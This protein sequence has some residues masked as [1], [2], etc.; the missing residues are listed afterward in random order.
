MK[1][2]AIYFTN[3]QKMHVPSGKLVLVGRD[4]DPE[5]LV[6]AVTGGQTTVYLD[7]ICAV[8]PIMEEDD[9]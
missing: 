9:D 8:R 5:T 4:V 3:G 1:Y 2:Y 6:D 7:T